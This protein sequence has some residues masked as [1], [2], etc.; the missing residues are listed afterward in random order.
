MSCAVQVEPVSIKKFIAVIFL[1]VL[2]LVPLQVAPATDGT[3][4]IDHII[5]IFQENRT[6]EDYFGTYP[7]ANGLNP[8]LALPVSPNS[9]VKVRPF[10]LNSTNMYM[11][12]VQDLNHAATVARIAYDNGKMDGFVYAE[13]SELTMG[14]YDYTDIPCYWDYA[15]RFVLMDNFFSSEMGPS[16]P[17]HLYLIAAQ[18]DNLTENADHFAFGFKTVVDELD[19]HHI[20]WK[21]YD[22][23]EL[24]YATAGL[25]NPLPAFE[26]FKKN[27][28]RMEN[29][30]RNG[31]FLIDLAHG[32]LPNVAWVMPRVQESEHPPED[33]VVGEHYVVSLVNAVMNSTYWKSC[34][35]FVTWDDYGGF[36]NHVPPPQLDSFG[37][38]F[39]VPCLII[40]P[41]ARQGYIDHS[42][43]EFSSI[44]KF[45]ETAYSLP[46]L[47]QRDAT[48][49]NMLEAFD[50]SQRPRT[51][52][53]L[54]GQYLPDT[55]PLTP[56]G[57]QNYSWLMLVVASLI[58]I[59]LV[60]VALAKFRSS[61]HSATT[62]A[63]AK[64]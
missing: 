34:A 37:L 52:L 35:I 36:Y 49:S 29:L 62:G 2:G 48:T 1:L 8:E 32:T 15:S 20:S 10:H 58:L 51:P 4:P 31:Q 11:T 43:S 46:P 7:G 50:F 16:L 5:V 27:Q 19:N 24:G 26:S 47:T 55:Y 25:W 13:K 42:Q 3:I 40:S 6:F 30:A 60:G 9:N 56:V 53:I 17:N 23:G 14:Y 45:I 38:G 54:P 28:T 64:T 21:Y 61:V 22:D 33:V 44:L 18:S 63:F 12:N 39:R 59:L 41:Y 57:T